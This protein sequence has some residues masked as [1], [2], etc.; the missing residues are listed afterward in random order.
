MADTFFL[1]DIKVLTSGVMLDDAD[2]VLL[3]MKKLILR[4]MVWRMV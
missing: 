2:A 1:P 3:N 4:T